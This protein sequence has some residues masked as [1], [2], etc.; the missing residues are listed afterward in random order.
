MVVA[1]THFK[2]MKVM[3]T[4]HGMYATKKLT[5]KDEIKQ[6]QQHIED[7]LE[8]VELL[9]KKKLT[10]KAKIQIEKV[11]LENKVKMKEKDHLLSNNDLSLNIKNKLDTYHDR[12]EKLMPEDD[13][14]AYWKSYIQKDHEDRK[15]Q[16]KKSKSRGK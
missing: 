3:L 7:L 4:H 5:P 12:L 11:C 15:A 9:T 14:Q 2:G 10:K 13:F 8:C 1:F 16:M 6:T